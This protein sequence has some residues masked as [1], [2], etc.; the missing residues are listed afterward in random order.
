[1]KSQ[2]GFSADHS[3]EGAVEELI[4]A[5]KN[6]IFTNVEARRNFHGNYEVADLKA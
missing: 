2:L 3:V 5:M 6:E 4:A 1:M